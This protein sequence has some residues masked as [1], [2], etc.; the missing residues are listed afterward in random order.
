MGKARTEISTKRILAF[1]Q[2][3]KISGYAVMENGKLKEYGNVDLTK[4][5]CCAEDRIKRM[6]Y[7][8]WAIIDRVRPTI[9]VLED[10]E[11]VAN[12]RAVI[13]LARLL[14]SMQGYCVANGIEYKTY[15]PS[16]WR[17]ILGYTQGAGVKRE[18]L[19][20]KSVEYAKSVTGEN[21]QEDTAEAV[22][23]AHAAYK[24]LK[25]I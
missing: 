8:L 9:V 1:D 11:V 16:T 19:K 2:A 23:I 17:K 13:M 4:S 10:V 18:E 25:E 21:V 3:T 5:K 15:M 22:A 12:M 7:E 20:Q 24:D 14:G 6:A